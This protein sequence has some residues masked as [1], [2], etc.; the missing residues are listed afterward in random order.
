MDPNRPRSAG[1]GRGDLAYA[2]FYS[3][4]IGG[5]VVALVFLV[6]D[7]LAGR[8]LFTPGLL[9]S[10]L[11]QGR[12]AA[13]IVAP[14]LTAVALFT[15]VHFAAF[16]GLGLVGTLVFRGSQAVEAAPT[17]V[18]GLT[19][20]VLMQGGML[21]ASATFLP[22]VVPALGGAAVLAANVLT[23]VAMTLFV[24]GVLA[25]RYPVEPES[26]ESEEELAERPG[27]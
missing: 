10:V 8:P 5:S 2:T 27:L 23:A 11:F 12:A 21:L 6:V 4:A 20:F 17:V 22:G 16:G 26:A 13:D 25:P 15:M 14:D 7:G 24:R 9:G 19:L 3:G 1:T 18:T